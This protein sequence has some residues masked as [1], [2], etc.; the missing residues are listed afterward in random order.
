MGVNV[1]T[2][3]L[4]VTSRESITS[5]FEHVQKRTGDKLDV[6]VNN[7]GVILTG[8]LIHVSMEDARNI[9]DVNMFGTLAVARA[10]TPLLVRTRG[11][12]LNILSLAGAVPMAWQGVYNS[13]KATKTF[14]PETLRIERAPVGVRVVTA[15]SARCRHP[16]EHIILAQGWG[17]SQLNNE[18]PRITAQNLVS[19][20]LGRKRGKT[21]RGRV[22]GF[23]SVA[24]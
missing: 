8:S 16:V 6:L 24:S 20:T 11:V 7:A 9:Y 2:I 21:W 10:F 17:Q 13:S 14:L 15:W 19:D 12:I 3:S 5:C 23:A 18:D 1:E 4:D 22:A